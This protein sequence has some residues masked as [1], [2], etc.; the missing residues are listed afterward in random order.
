MKNYNHY[1]RM[2]ICAVSLAALGLAL[3]CS[4]NV[5]DAKDY[6][7]STNTW[8]DTANQEVMNRKTQERFLDTFVDSFYVRVNKVEKQAKLITGTSYDDSLGKIV[9]Y[10]RYT[11]CV[12]GF[13]K[14]DDMILFTRDIN[15]TQEQAVERGVV[16]HAPAHQVHLENVLK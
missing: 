10:P 5:D 1:N 16:N 7:Q 6:R 12:N 8:S 4:K 11:V 2:G 14:V 9:R 13:Y 15:N 3:G